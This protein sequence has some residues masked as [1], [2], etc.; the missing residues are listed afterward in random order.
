MNDDSKAEEFSFEKSLNELEALVSESEDSTLQLEDMVKNYE[1]G[2]K[3]IA[4]CRTKLE[5]AELRISQ[6]SSAKPSSSTEDA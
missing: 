4:M 2:K 6:A 1:K 5:A 3:L